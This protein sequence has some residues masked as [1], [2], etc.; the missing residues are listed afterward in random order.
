MSKKKS[1]LE[2]VKNFL[3]YRDQTGQGPVDHKALI[4]S[5]RNTNYFR[6]LNGKEEE[7]V[8]VVDNRDIQDGKPNNRVLIACDHASNDLKYTKLEDYEEDLIRS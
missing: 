8:S 3:T 2:G 1:V 4:A 5:L 6:S 7:A